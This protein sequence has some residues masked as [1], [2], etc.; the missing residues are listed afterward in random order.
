MIR[1]KKLYSIPKSFEP[2]N[3]ES[4]LNIILGEKSE[5]NN[6][7]NGVGKTMSI[8]FLNFC[9]LKKTSDSRVTL[10]PDTVLE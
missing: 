10:I 2:I 7:T 4:G 1:L 5:G 9:L 8:E 3:F 6:K